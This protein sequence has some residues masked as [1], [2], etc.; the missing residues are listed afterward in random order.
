MCNLPDE[1]AEKHRR[2]LSGRV[3]PGAGIYRTHEIPGQFRDLVALRRQGAR[4]RLRRS[5]AKPIEALEVPRPLERDVGWELTS[6]PPVLRKC[7]KAD[8]GCC[9]ADAAADE[10][11][12]A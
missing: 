5:P 11:L 10:R 3:H 2:G 1:G 12:V 9:V 6:R 4:R 8:S 7:D